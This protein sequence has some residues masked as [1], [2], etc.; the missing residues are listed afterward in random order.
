MKKIY[1]T[2]AVKD[3]TNCLGK[4]RFTNG[5]VQFERKELGIG[6]VESSL[7]LGGI[8]GS[9]GL[10]ALVFV[11]TCGVLAGSKIAIGTVI[12]PSSVYLLDFDALVDGNQDKSPDFENK[13]AYIPGAMNSFY[14][15]PSPRLNYDRLP[16][17]F[18]VMPGLACANPIAISNSQKRAAILKKYAI[19]AEHLELASVGAFGKKCNKPVY[20]ILGVANYIRKG[21]HEEWIKNRALAEGNSCQF[22]KWFCLNYF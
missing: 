10:S 8:I 13:R 18:R 11:G 21:A 7:T 5:N 12:I 3:E 2:S 6:L 15:F 19:K 16:F 1:I 9:P 22:A 4:K 14:S 17:D 20:A